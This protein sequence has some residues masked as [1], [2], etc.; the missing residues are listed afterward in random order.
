MNKM[1]YTVV[2]EKQRT[3]RAAVTGGSQDLSRRCRN[4]HPAYSRMHKRDY[5]D[6]APLLLLH[7]V[8]DRT[9]RRCAGGVCGDEEGADIFTKSRHKGGAPDMDL[10]KPENITELIKAQRVLLRKYAQHMRY[11]V[12]EKYKNAALL[13]YWLFDYL[14]YLQM[15]DT[16]NP[17][18]NIKYQR[19]Q[20]VYV[21][22]GYRIGSELGGCHYAIVLDVKNSKTNSQVTVI[23]LKSKREK[24]T[25]Y[26]A[27]YHVDIQSEI[28]R[29]LLSKAKEIG[30]VEREKLQQSATPD[31]IKRVKKQL[32]I[33]NS[34]IDFAE[35]KM[36][37][38]S[39]A[40]LGQISTISK[41]R[42]V[43]PTKTRD[44]LSGICLSDESMR[45]IEDKLHFL[46]FSNRV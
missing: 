36:N 12:N 43:H 13:T 24:E 19:G 6:V 18:F 42:I 10:K 30:R 27:V 2:K 1:L 9:I 14:R 31:D 41:I 34:V 29:L 28:F 32:N 16:F 33:A 21:N 40:D 17:R 22:F 20:I 23:P 46:F 35:E 44:P 5:S 4:R 8:S 37:K 11:L 45:R 25:P 7:G 26:S 39:V 3:E 15:E 38:S